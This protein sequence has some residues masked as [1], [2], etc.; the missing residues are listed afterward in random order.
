VVLFGL[1]FSAYFKTNFIRPLATLAWP[2]RRGFAGAGV[3][4]ENITFSAALPHGTRTHLSPASTSH[5]APKVTLAQSIP[6][7]LMRPSDTA[8]IPTGRRRD[9]AVAD[10]SDS[11]RLFR[12]ATSCRSR[13]APASQ[14]RRSQVLRM[15]YEVRLCGHAALSKG[16]FYGTDTLRTS[17][18]YCPVDGWAVARMQIGRV[19][20]G[21]QMVASSPQL[22]SR[23][24]SCTP[25]VA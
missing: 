19:A 15:C 3:T 2:P 14:G 25:R 20:K 10:D 4:Q 18:P 17:K 9:T 16:P 24:R 21:S 13:R 23:H 7:H 6:V 5:T 22:S 8:A 1:Q 11:L 12:P